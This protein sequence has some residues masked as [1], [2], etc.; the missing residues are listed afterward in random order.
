AG[1]AGTAAV[2]TGVAVWAFQSPSAAPPESKDASVARKTQDVN[3]L[4][5]TALQQLSKDS[6]ASARTYRHV[7][8]LDPRNKDAWY[9]LGLIAQ[10]YGQT[11][12]A[13]ADYDMALK[14]D[15][16]FMSALYS[17]ALLLKSSEPDRAIELLK[18]A[19]ATE[20]KSDAIHMQ[21]GLLLAE[22]D[23]ND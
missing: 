22:R 9:G 18:R 19:A 23:R 2:A 20:P 16:S 12:D 21:L 15:P 3:A 8:E 17:E 10:Q 4:L 1:L 14:I 6:R 7:L 11:T 5:Q 13:R